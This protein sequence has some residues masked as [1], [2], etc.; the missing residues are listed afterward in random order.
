ME[1]F[2][3]KGVHAHVALTGGPRHKTPVSDDVSLSIFQRT[4]GHG[5]SILLDIS[6]VSRAV[7]WLVAATGAVPNVEGY[8]S[9]LAPSGPCLHPL[10]VVSSVG[11]YAD[12][13]NAYVADGDVVVAVT[14]FATDFANQGSQGVIRLTPAQAVELRDWLAAWHLHGWP[15]VRHGAGPTAVSA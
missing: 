12:V 6:G 1:S 4:M 13:L 3:A 15:G 11:A 8:R 14:H 2:A 10:V 9:C 5:A 7:Q